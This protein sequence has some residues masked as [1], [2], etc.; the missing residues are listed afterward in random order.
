M[1]RVVRSILEVAAIAAASTSLLA[2]GHGPVFGLATPTN[3]RGGW[4]ADW[5]L[6]GRYGPSTA[7]TMMRLGLGYGIT[8]HLK[9]SVT[10]PVVF[11]TDSLAPARVAPFT[12][13]GNDFEGQVLWRFQRKTVGVGSRL[14]TT[15]IGGV[16]ATGPQDMG[17]TLKPIQ[18]SAG[19]LVGIVSGYASRSHYL[20]GGT[21]YQRYAESSG[22]RRPDLLF[23][24]AV[25][26]Y[27]P[28]S[29]RKDE[30]WDWR[31]IGELTGERAGSIQQAGTPLAGSQAHQIFVGPSTLAVWKNY[32]I[33]FGVLFPVYRAVNPIYYPSERVRFSINFAYFF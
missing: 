24:S 7:G 26:A 15:A 25:Y 6:M 19:G 32:G 29:W 20:W 1:R 14:E 5:G 21:T 31:I 30:G 10:A 16:L 9:I 28:K 8:E 12:P 23:Y 4:S 17:G 3:P 18:S 33:G 27:R 2:S 22:D 11:R 13:M